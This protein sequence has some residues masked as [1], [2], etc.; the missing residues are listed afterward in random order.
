[1]ITVS[2]AIVKMISDWGGSQHDICH[3]LKVLA[4]AKTIGEM[5]GISAEEQQTLE[6][7]AIVHDIACPELR[8]K[9]GN[10]PWDLQERFGPPLV[11]EFYQDAGME[12]KMLSRICYLVG[13]HHTITNVDGMDYR[14]LLEADFLVNAGEQ[15]SYR[16]NVNEFR[17]KVFKTKT[18]LELL[19]KMF[20]MVE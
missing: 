14:I 6:F 3:F 8:K 12:E 7:A 10:A 5:E 18:G 2:E 9:Y 4:Y 15:E 19:E 1:M 16:E 17:E 13:N 20:I 11:R